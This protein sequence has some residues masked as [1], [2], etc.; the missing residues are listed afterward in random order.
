ML[1]PRGS[2]FAGYASG[3]PRD[4]LEPRFPIGL[5][6]SNA[7]CIHRLRHSFTS[8]ARPFSESPSRIAKLI[9]YWWL[10]VGAN[11][12]TMPPCCARAAWRAL[13]L[14]EDNTSVAMECV[15]ISWM[16]PIRFGKVLKDSVEHSTGINLQRPIQKTQEL[17]LLDDRTLTTPKD[18]L[19][20]QRYTDH[21]RIVHQPTQRPNLWCFRCPVRQQST[22]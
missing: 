13:R 4:Y 2:R 11:R 3:I 5:P 7:A 8:W 14:R 12:P 19:P 9:G 22:Q 15:N 1:V 20:S 18:S 21:S 17:R 10:P 6:S 16:D